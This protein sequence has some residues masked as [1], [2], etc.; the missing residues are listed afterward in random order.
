MQTF[1]ALLGIALALTILVVVL[2]LIGSVFVTAFFAV[3][4]K[5][6]PV[7]YNIRSLTRR[8]VT[9]TVT[10]L[11]MALAVGVFSAG[12]QLRNG[13]KKTLVTAGRED[14]V[15]IL[16]KGSNA[17]ITSVVDREQA[18]LL[19]SRDEVAI[20]PKDGKPLADPQVSVLIFA[21]RPGGISTDGTN[22]FVRGLSERTTAIHP[23][24]KVIEGRWFQ[25]GTSE[26]VIGKSLVGKFVN[27]QLGQ[28]MSFARRGWKV[29]GVIDSGG[30]SF[31]SEVWGDLEQ[32]MAAFQRTLYS[33]L[34]VR[35]KDKKTI[36]QMAEGVALDPRLSL[37][38]K[39]EQ[40]Y[41][42]DLSSGL[43]NLLGFLGLFVA[44]V[45]SLGATLGATISMYAQVAAR[46]RE[47]GVLRAL[48]F[49]RSAIFVSFVLESV[50]LGLIAGG[51][52]LGLS[53]FM[54]FASFSTMSFGTFSQVTFCF[55]LTPDV[56]WKSAI[57]ATMMGYAG[58]VLPATR[59]FRTPITQAV[60]GA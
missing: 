31:D 51:V 36:P 47:V 38:V 56:F 50:L 55:A 53:A 34:V 41:Y 52:G 27:A 42:E 10:V 54:Q 6:I 18:K 40:K 3:D 19:A 4:S 60:K 12:L 28:E 1:A 9:T 44:V 37:D 57:F 59:A 5:W 20:D 46:I 21:Q 58:G 17:E 30:S 16:R 26:I 2:F 35:V 23:T 49:R 33:A 45:F 15:V 8:R 48:G 32:V 14:N 25:P 11:G 43:S 39:M 24:V 7:T 22:V 29:V 13:I